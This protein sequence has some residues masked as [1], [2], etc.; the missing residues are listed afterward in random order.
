MIGNTDIRRWIKRQKIN[1]EAREQERKS[2]MGGCKER[3]SDFTFHLLFV[4]FSLHLVRQREWEIVFALAGC[5]EDF[6]GW[7]IHF[8]TGRREIHT[9]TSV[10]WPE[11]LC[12]S[13]CV[14]W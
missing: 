9:L 13:L 6:E 4:S 5:N 11:C 8:N 1:I 3:E 14:R 7:M 10:S 2:K 12:E